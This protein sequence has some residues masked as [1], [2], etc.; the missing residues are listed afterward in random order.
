M[1]F[2]ILFA[3]LALSVFTVISMPSSEKT[4]EFE[5]STGSKASSTSNIDLQNVELGI[6]KE[7]QIFER[8]KRFYPTCSE[9][10]Q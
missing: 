5:T 7:K 2:A 4:E 10:V 9:L 1:K 6:D 8:F 3:F